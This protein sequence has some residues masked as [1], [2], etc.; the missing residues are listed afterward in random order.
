M[1]KKIFSAEQMQNYG[2]ALAVSI[3]P[4]QVILLHGPL[5][6]G[7]TTLVRG[8]LGALGFTDKVKSPTYTLVETYLTSRFIVHHFD[9]YRLKSYQELL[10]IG[11]DDYLDQDAVCLIEWP[12]LI[13]PQLKNSIAVS[14]EPTNECREVSCDANMFK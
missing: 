13:K 6:A 10:D 2:A 7:K 1:I 11:I 5:G 3:K 14:I 4:G 9:L 12:E 8:F